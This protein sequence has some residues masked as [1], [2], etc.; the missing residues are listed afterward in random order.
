[1][2]PT[3][4]LQRMPPPPPSEWTVRELSLKVSEHKDRAVEESHVSL[5]TELPVVHQ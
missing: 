4:S 1:M 2:I 5:A 3:P